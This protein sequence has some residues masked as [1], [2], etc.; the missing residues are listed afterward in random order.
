MWKVNLGFTPK[1]IKIK[2]ILNTSRLSIQTRH[3]PSNRIHLIPERGGGGVADISDI[4]IFVT[5]FKSLSPILIMIVGT[6]TF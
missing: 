1:L 6:I 4:M 2:R 5:E 3:K